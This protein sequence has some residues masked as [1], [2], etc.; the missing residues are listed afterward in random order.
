MHLFWPALL[1][2]AAIASLA[3]ACL[4]AWHDFL[5]PR[6]AQQT[7]RLNAIQTMNTRSTVSSLQFKRVLCLNDRAAVFL[8]NFVWILALDKLLVQA[9]IHYRVDQF[10][11]F[12]ALTLVGITVAC[13]VL[14]LNISFSAFLLGLTISV[15]FGYLVLKRQNRRDLIDDQLP[16]ALDLISQ[17]MQAGHAL[18]SAILLASNEGSDPMASELRGVFDEI[19]YGI[20]TRQ[21]I[22]SLSERIDSEYI[23]LFVTSVLIQIDTGGNMAEILKS[24]SFLIRDRKKFKAAAR[25]LTA[26]A[27]I[28][29]LILGA[30]PFVIVGLLMVIN[31]AF[32]SVLWQDPLG[33]KL[34]MTSLAMMVVG[35]LW[36]WRLIHTPY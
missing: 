33:L 31:P 19:N 2:F 35:A 13:G 26:E 17:A 16:E 21:A 1:V 12:L 3:G 4:F 18:S 34:L 9:G 11:S 14:S 20:S 28:S 7:S 25:V 32:I 10:L 8:K 24:T 36:M 27:R 30:L 5:S 22:L 15:F 6:V 29:A 23:R